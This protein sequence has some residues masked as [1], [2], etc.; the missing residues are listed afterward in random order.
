LL[1]ATIIADECAI[2]DGIATA[3]MVMGKDKSIEFM[4]LHPEFEA[5]LI[6]SDDTGNFKTWTS[7]TLKEYISESESN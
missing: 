5:Y 3:C 1:S 4:D 6:Y 2:A 7:E